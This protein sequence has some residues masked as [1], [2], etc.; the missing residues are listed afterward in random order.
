VI[1]FFVLNGSKT[2]VIKYEVLP[3]D[4]NHLDKIFLKSNLDSTIKANMRNSIH[5][6][7]YFSES[8]F[9]QTAISDIQPFK[10]FKEAVDNVADVLNEQNKRN[11]LDTVQIKGVVKEGKLI[12]PTR[13][14]YSKRFLLKIICNGHVGIYITDLFGGCGNQLDLVYNPYIGF[15][16]YTD[17]RRLYLR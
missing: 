10:N 13:E 1:N 16:R 8:D 3:L 14:L 12:F 2:D 4:N 5:N 17:A 7:I 15:Q 11:K 6:G 9:D